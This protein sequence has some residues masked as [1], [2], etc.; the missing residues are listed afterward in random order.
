MIIFI[1]AALLGAWFGLRIFR[2]RSDR[3]FQVAVRVLLVAVGV[4]LVL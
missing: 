3:Q 2:G 1:L 4:G